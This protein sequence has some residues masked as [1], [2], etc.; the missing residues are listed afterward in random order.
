[1]GWGGVN[2]GKGQVVAT[3]ERVGELPHRCYARTEHP[4]SVHS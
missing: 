4:H 3:K 2:G 1:M